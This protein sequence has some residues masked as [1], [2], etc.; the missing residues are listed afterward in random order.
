M[1]KILTLYSNDKQEADFITRSAIKEGYKQVVIY[2]AKNIHTPFVKQFLIIEGVESVGQ[3]QSLTI[4][5][6]GS[7]ADF[8]IIEDNIIQEDP[9]E[10]LPGPRDIV[11]S[12]VIIT[13]HKPVLQFVPEAVESIIN[14]C[15][16]NPVIHLISDGLPTSEDPIYQKYKDVDCVRT[17]YNKPSGPYVAMNRAF[18]F[19]ETD[20]ISILDSDDIAMPNRLWRAIKALEY[21]GADIYGGAMEQFID[22]RYPNDKTQERLESQPIVQSENRETI[23]HGVQTCKKSVFKDVNGYADYFCG[24]DWHFIYRAKQCGYKLYQSHHIVAIRRLHGASLTNNST[25]G[26]ATSFRKQIIKQTEEDYNKIR[27]GASPQEFG[28][29]DK[30]INSDD[31]YR[32]S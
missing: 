17:Y 9:E 4:K 29:L 6:F 7:H 31:I 5:K 26:F 18:Q 15:F 22:N 11:E 19:M 32:T 16:A 12:D 24:A 27:R 20:Y 28:A 14:Q 25:H 30:Y 8:G 2:T 1:N 10:L 21:S 13:Y 23:I 3:A